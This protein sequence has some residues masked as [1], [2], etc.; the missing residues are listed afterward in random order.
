MINWI[1]SWKAGNKKEKYQIDIRIGK[2]TVL[3]VMF[4]PCEFCENEK[5]SCSRFRFMI[6]NLGFEL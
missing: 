4:C 5:T 3:E 1:N 2:L 6:F